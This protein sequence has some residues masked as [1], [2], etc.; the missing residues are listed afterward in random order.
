MTKAGWILV[1]DE[2]PRDEQDVLIYV[3]GD[4][5]QERSKHL[6]IF[7]KQGGREYKWICSYAHWRLNDV[8]HWMTMPDDPSGGGE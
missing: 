6:A 7:T 2:L 1:R 3:P 8:S 4:N 5:N